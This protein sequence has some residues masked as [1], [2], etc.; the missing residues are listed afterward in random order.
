MSDIM[1]FGSRE[2][3]RKWLCENCLSGEGIWLIQQNFLVR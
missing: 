1:E 2:E 3:F